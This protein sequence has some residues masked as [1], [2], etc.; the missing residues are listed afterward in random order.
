METRHPRTVG[1]VGGGCSVPCGFPEGEGSAL[2]HETPLRVLNGCC[3]VPSRVREER[4]ST[5]RA[6][7]KRKRK[8]KAKKPKAKKRKRG[9]RRSWRG[10]VPPIII[11]ITQFHC[12]ST[13]YEN[14]ARAVRGPV[15]T[16]GYL[17]PQVPTSQGT[18]NTSLPRYLPYGVGYLGRW[19]SVG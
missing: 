13:Q 1:R 2:A 3:P 4:G 18:L 9:M 19:V 15:P 11:T 16:P 14:A 17:P 12:F 6:K 8:K 10:R 7:K 5:K